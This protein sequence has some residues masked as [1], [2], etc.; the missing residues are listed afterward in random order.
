MK[1][2]NKKKVF[3]FYLF[4]VMLLAVLPINS[5]GSSLNNNYVLSIRLDYF[6]HFIV[7]LPYFFLLNI[8][9]KKVRNTLFILLIAILFASLV[10]AIQYPLSY[11]TFNINDL[12]ANWIGILLSFGLFCLIPYIKRKENDKYSQ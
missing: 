1:I 11:R 7:L 4:L 3:Y 6:A 10:E 2:L 9:F 5:T 12:A 8:E